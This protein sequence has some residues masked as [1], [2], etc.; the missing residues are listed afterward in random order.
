[1]S[2]TPI[3]FAVYALII[4]Y[5]LLCHASVIDYD[6]YPDG[7]INLQDIEPLWQCWLQNAAENDCIDV[8][9]WVDNTINLKD[10]ALFA[11]VW[12]DIDPNLYLVGKW[13]FDQ[14]S[15]TVAPDSSGNGHAG[16]VMNDIS[17]WTSGWISNAVDLD[18]YNDYIHLY[19][20]SNGLG[21]YFTRDFTIAAWMYPYDLNDY[22][23]LI[24]IESTSRF[25]INGF[26]GLTV[27]FYNGL[28]SMYIAYPDPGNPPGQSTI[29]ETPEGNTPLTV[30]QWQHLCIVRSGPE[31]KFYLNGQ[32]DAVRKVTDANIH[33]ISDWPGYDSIGA[34]SDSWYGVTGHFNGIIDE[35]HLY[36]KAM[37][38]DVVLHL[39]RQYLA[40]N[41]SPTDLADQVTTNTALSWCP[42]LLEQ[43]G[44]DVYF[45]TDEASVQAADMLTPGIYK[46]R[47]TQTTFNP[48]SLSPNTHYFWRID[49][50][51]GPQI[52]TGDVWTFTTSYCDFTTQSSSWQTGYPANG[53]MEGNRFSFGAN[54]CWKGDTGQPS[55]WWQVD[56]E[57]AITIGS[58]LQIT[59]DHENTLENAP[60][61][62]E[63]I[64]SMDGMTWFNLPE[65]SVSGERRIYRI[66]R[67]S[68]PI[69]TKYLRL[70]IT[71]CAGAYPTLR[72]VE[73]YA[74]TDT[75]IAFPD[76]VVGVDII[77]YPGMPEYTQKFFTLIDD[78]P[79]WTDTKEQLIWLGNF[80]ESF[81]GIE[82]YPLCVFLSG[83]FYDWC[84]RT[85][86]PFAG[87]QEVLENE[88]IPVWGSCGGAQAIGIL[89]DTGYQSPW[90][91]P[92]CRLPHDPYS[93]IYGHIG[94]LDPEDPGPCGDYLHAIM[95]T[96][97]TY[98][99]KMTDDPVLDTLPSEFLVNESHMGQLEYLPVNW[100]QICTISPH[101][102]PTVHT[103]LQLC[104]RIDKPIYAAQFHIENPDASTWDN[105]ITIMSNFLTISK[106]WGG[107]QSD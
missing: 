107:Y 25:E 69:L 80:D 98:I 4:L 26:E 33:F 71:D 44:H 36:N 34:T 50:V 90:D 45:G 91:C 99:L 81:L 92:R 23:V 49:E 10:L 6:V 35:V 85:R 66:Y 95:E 105:S 27:E 82:P 41:P 78:C 88:N 43:D 5:P 9:V 24:G 7:R 54:Q 40:W 68:A 60:T 55:W 52:H 47:Q 8:D 46:G 12:N 103:D 22:Q 57:E 106:Q 32:L 58:I 70:E 2:K 51:N 39:A 72:E 14:S 20:S 42:G 16:T 93:P 30:N 100:Q 65:T 77:E 56:F 48:G 86:P 37:S 17:P 11:S 89:L 31:V 75:A 94:Y 38:E 19:E 1:M 87:L 21:Q 13:K 102:D 64:W 53:A 73:F 28:P 29:R 104:K 59:G 67:L 63:W 101:Y 97:P 61:N 83:S 18:G 3:Q 76:W 62:Y 79:G 84:E 96:G 15:G 74:D